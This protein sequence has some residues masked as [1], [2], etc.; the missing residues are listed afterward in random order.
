MLGTYT[1][2]P[3]TP[4]T[5][6]QTPFAASSSNPVQIAALPLERG[7]YTCGTFWYMLILSILVAA[8]ASKASLL[9]PGVAAK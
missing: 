9:P 5:H 1:F 7:Q 8:E 3:A 2:S 6:A 4:T